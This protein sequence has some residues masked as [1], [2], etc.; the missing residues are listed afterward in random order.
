MKTGVRNIIKNQCSCLE[1]WIYCTS[2]FRISHLN[3]FGHVNR[4]ESKRKVSQIFNNNPEGS[5]LNGRSKNRWWNCVQTDIN[6]CKT[7]KLK[8]RS[9]NN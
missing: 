6:K 9:I 1:I 3:L 8:E 4:M 5:R 7:A 2:I